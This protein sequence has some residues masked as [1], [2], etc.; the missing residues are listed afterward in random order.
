MRKDREDLNKFKD[1]SITICH[2][3]RCDAD[4][5]NNETALRLIEMD[6]D[7]QIA[8]SGIL[9]FTIVTC[10]LIYFLF[11]SQTNAILCSYS[12]LG[13]LVPKHVLA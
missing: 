10:S 11:A 12:Y 9:P 4:E 2:L 7:I 13:V 5:N 3:S 8:I 1:R 6:G